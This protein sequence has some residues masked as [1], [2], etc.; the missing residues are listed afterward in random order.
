MI[1]A[2]N[3]LEN[4]VTAQEKVDVVKVIDSVLCDVGNVVLRCHQIAEITTLNLE[5]REQEYKRRKAREEVV[6]ALFSYPP[7]SVAMNLR[8]IFDAQTEGEL[9]SMFS[10][11]IFSHV[12][13]NNPF[14]YFQH[15][16]TMGNKQF[17]STCEFPGCVLL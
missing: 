3:M 10:D 7:E 12:R 16:P 14:D 15:L 11:D 6:L 4:K 2:R 9:V 13:K 1:P 8:R 5:D 17:Y